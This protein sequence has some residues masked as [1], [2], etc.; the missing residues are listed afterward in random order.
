MN[1][2]D[3]AVLSVLRR[4]EDQTILCL[5]NLA[6]SPQRATLDPAA[7]GLLPETTAEPVVASPGLAPVAGPLPHDVTLP[8]YGYVWLKLAPPP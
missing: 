7:T 8:P 2:G 6:D 1:L 3:K 4:G 5:L